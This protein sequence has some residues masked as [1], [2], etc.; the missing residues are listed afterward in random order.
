MRLWHVFFRLVKYL[1]YVLKSMRLK[2][3]IKHV[4]PRGYNVLDS[5]RVDRLQYDCNICECHCLHYFI[6]RIYCVS[7][8][9]YV[10]T[11]V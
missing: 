6:F 4:L 10:P 9:T 1:K 7:D 3:K 5:Q 11:C 2:D 8:V